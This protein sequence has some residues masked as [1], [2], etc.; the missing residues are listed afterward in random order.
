MMLDGL[1]C[2]EFF[3]HFCFPNK[4]LFPA[5]ILCAIQSI[6]IC[7]LKIKNIRNML[8]VLTNQITDIWHFND[9]LPYTIEEGR[10]T[11]LF[12]WKKRSSIK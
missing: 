2:F 5:S 11:H 7:T 4:L 10:Q 12:S 1:D 8:A 9:M 3:K 6:D